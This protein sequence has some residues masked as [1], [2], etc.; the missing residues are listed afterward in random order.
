MSGTKKHLYFISLT[1]IRIKLDDWDL[2]STITEPI[3]S[4][5]NGTS[6]KLKD[7][8]VKIFKKILPF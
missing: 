1:L 6:K 2:I 3:K 4:D 7:L 8:K 5:S